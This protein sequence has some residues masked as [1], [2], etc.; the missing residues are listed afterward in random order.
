MNTDTE[1][2]SGAQRCLP[3]LE[4]Y[5][6]CLH[7]RKEVRPLYVAS[8]RSSVLRWMLIRDTVTRRQG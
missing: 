3:A 8:P 5:Y 1:D 2:T 6:E 7:H 4:D